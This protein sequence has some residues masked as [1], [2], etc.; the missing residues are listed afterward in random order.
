MSLLLKISE[1]IQAKS[2]KHIA[3]E[4]HNIEDYIHAVSEHIKGQCQ[5][6]ES[7]IA[8]ELKRSL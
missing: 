7:L 8:K 1:S 2:A 3:E 5:K 4:Q 6:Y